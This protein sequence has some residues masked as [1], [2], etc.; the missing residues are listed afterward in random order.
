MS[1]STGT[2]GCGSSNSSSSNDEERDLVSP[3]SLHP[4]PG[5]ISPDDTLESYSPR[6]PNTQIIAQLGQHINGEYLTETFDLFPQEVLNIPSV[7]RQ[8]EEPLRRTQQQYARIL[9]GNLRSVL[10]RNRNLGIS[11]WSFLQEELQNC[12]HLVNGPGDESIFQQTS[13]DSA[14][15]ENQ[16]ENHQLAE[17]QANQETMKDDMGYGNTQDEKL[18]EASSK[19][20]EI[21]D[22][23]YIIAAIMRVA[24]ISAQIVLKTRNI[25]NNLI[26]KLAKF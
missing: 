5:E 7:T 16:D 3:E 15:L 1:Y 4:S 26:L 19:E 14:G 11:D 13:S 9:V 12:L 17:R 25:A 18:E 2:I 23:E 10:Q 6:E 22:E 20:K 24:T 8:D 21:G